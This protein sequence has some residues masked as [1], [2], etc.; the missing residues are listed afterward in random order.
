M[1]RQQY[2][3]NDETMYI[4]ARKNGYH[5][6]SVVGELYG[7]SIECFD[8]PNK[9]IEQN[10]K[11]HSQSYSSRKD[12]TRNLSNIRSKQPVIIDLF[13][14][15]IY[16][17]THSDRITENNWFNLKYINSYSQY[18]GVTKI[19]FENNEELVIE[20]SYSSFNNQYLNA[21]KLYYK[22]NLQREKYNRKTEA[23]QYSY[24][25]IKNAQN[26]LEFVNEA[27]RS[28]YINY[29]RGIDKINTLP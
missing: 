6:E 22:F 10:C 24:D 26:D 7:D 28:A 17:C 18:N 13:G 27:A 9:V 12:L 1:S 29:I 5:T 8:I 4:V 25:N 19:K 3:I 16:F 21:I 11:Y 23:T 15:Y 2:I 20:I 14:G